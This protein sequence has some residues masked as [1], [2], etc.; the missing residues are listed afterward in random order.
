MWDCCLRSYVG[1]RERAAARRGT[2]EIWPQEALLVSGG[3]HVAPEGRIDQEPQSEPT[4]APYTFPHQRLE[5]RLGR[6]CQACMRTELSGEY[7]AAENWPRRRSR[8]EPLDN[9]SN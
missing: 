1:E 5:I 4:P 9:A 3:S 7:S 8:R 6:V 2:A